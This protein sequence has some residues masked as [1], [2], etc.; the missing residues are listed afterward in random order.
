MKETIRGFINEHSFRIRQKAAPTP[1]RTRITHQGRHFNLMDS[2]QT[3]NYRYFE[4]RIDCRITWGRRV[5]RTR[6]R[7]VRLGS[8]SSVAGIIRINP[9]LD[10]EYVPL[11]VIE[12]IIYHEM[13]HSLLG[14]RYVDGRRLSHYAEFRSLEKGY[15]HW[16]EA[17]AWIK[18][19][20]DLLTGKIVI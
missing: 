4:G 6:F 13:L 3:L 12:S 16:R 20:L 15:L 1:R 14:F 2:F 10:R 8:Y 17:K 5:R 9:M 18:K 11:Y 7:S 19:N